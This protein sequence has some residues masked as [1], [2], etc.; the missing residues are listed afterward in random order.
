[1]DLFTSLLVKII[2]AN[3]PL[4]MM[5]FCMNV[6]NKCSKNGPEMQRAGR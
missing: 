4:T 2:N 5:L 1:M 6:A 3:Q